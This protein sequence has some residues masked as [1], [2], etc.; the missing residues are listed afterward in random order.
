VGDILIRGKTINRFT[1]TA[2][3][4]SIISFSLLVLPQRKIPVFG[5]DFLLLRASGM[6]QGF[7]SSVELA[8]GQ[9]GMEKYRPGFLI[10]YATLHKVLGDTLSAYLIVNSI[11]TFALGLAFGLVLRESTKLKNFAIPVGIILISSMRFLW[12]SREWIYGL[13][14]IIALISCLLAI[15]FYLRSVKHLGCHSYMTFGNLFFLVSIFT[16]ERYVYV[17]IVVSIYFAF[18]NNRDAIK[19]STVTI[20]LP[21]IIVLFNFSVKILVLDVNPLQ[22]SLRDYQNLDSRNVF[23]DMINVITGAIF[24]LSGFS[25]YASENP[26]AT[27][28]RMV[29]VF[30]LLLI[31][32]LGVSRIFLRRVPTRHRIRSNF[33]ADNQFSNVL[34]TG[35]GTAGIGVIALEPYAAERFLVLSQLMAWI[36]LI[37]IAPRLFGSSV[38]FSP[39]VLVIS[40]ILITE[41]SYLP[42]REHW[43][44]LQKRAISTYEVLGP[45]LDGSQPWRLVTDVAPPIKTDVDWVLGY[46]NNHFVGVFVTSKNAPQSING[47]SQDELTCVVAKFEEASLD[48]TLS[49]C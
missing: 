34:I 35:L 40:L 21:S 10:A 42:A 37:N 17:G 2:W 47:N 41:W 16:A 36:L 1:F 15:Y 39:A 22:G 30:I 13:M 14:E 28:F 6:H 44:P 25:T 26:F 9:T 19:L 12:S 45:Y 20:A 8:F 5:D 32:T 23:A 43:S 4:M 49:P 33:F 48:T 27:S 46:P 7:G 38:G 3:L 18:L 11:L 29:S 24:K 31:L